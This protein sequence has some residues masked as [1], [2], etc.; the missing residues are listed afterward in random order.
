[1]CVYVTFTTESKCVGAKKY[2]NV[3]VSI[4]HDCSSVHRSFNTDDHTSHL[5]TYM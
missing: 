5:C 1:V 3:S 4:T 2:I